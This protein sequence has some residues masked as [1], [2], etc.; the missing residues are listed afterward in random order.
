[1]VTYVVWP[2]TYLR[3]GFR[4]LSPPSEILF[5]LEKIVFISLNIKIWQNLYVFFLKLFFYTTLIKILTS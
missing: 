5:E 1:M 4:S 3:R 2:K